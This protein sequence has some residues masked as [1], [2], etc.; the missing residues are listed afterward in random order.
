MGLDPDAPKGYDRSGQLAYRAQQQAAGNWAKGG[1]SNDVRLLDADPVFGNLDKGEAL[2]KRGLDFGLGSNNNAQT[3]AMLQQ[4]QGIGDQYGGMFNGLGQANS[5]RA[6][7]A[8]SRGLTPYRGDLTGYKQGLANAA[9]SRGM[10]T[11]SYGALMDFAKQGIGPSAAQAQ[12]TQATD[13]NTRNALAMARSGRGMGGSQAGLRSAMDQNAV[14]QQ[15]A[16]AQMAELRANEY[17][18]Y[19]NQKL[20]ALNAG[21][22]LA[23][24]IAGTDQS[25]GQLGLQGAQYQSDTAL[26][27]TQLNDATAQNWA[28]QQGNAYQQGL[29]AEMGAQTQKLNVNSTALTGRENEYASANSTYATEKGLAQ[30]A[31][32]ADANRTQAYTGA[33]LSTAGTVIGALSDERSKQNITP[34]GVPMAMPSASNGSVAGTASQGPSAAQQ[35]DAADKAQ[36]QSIG[37]GAG[38][39]VGGAVGG[40]LGAVAGSWIGSKLGGL[41]GSDIRSKDNI[42]PLGSSID[43][44]AEMARKYGAQ[45]FADSPQAVARYADATPKQL[46]REAKLNKPILSAGDALLADSARAVPGSRYEYKDASEPGAKAGPQVGP[47]AQDLA[48]NPL[49]RG[50]VIERPNG[51]L[52]VDAPRLTLYNTAQQHAQQNQTDALSARL[53]ELET[54]LRRKPGDERATS[55]QPS[56]GGL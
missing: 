2:A 18:A 17:T 10:Q 54:L 52:A 43:Y 20:N 26:K 33:G 7:A 3:E 49:T 45:G 34:L 23:S 30:A 40:P 36:G 53:G 4:A 27:G 55:F 32:I 6:A 14:T 48:A 35:A 8:E 41:L 31:A 16:A 21:G 24:Q 9:D 15:T 19:Q 56:T 46:S 1:R 51:K 25:Y 38:G 29:A 12:L 42:Q 5:D 37:K 13:A 39:L 50:T 11:G 44:G 28:T 22:G 47:M